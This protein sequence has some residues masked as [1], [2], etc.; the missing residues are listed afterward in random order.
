MGSGRARSI[1]PAVFRGRALLESPLGKQSLEGV[2]TPTT[3]GQ[4]DP[5]E[6]ENSPRTPPPVLPSSALRDILIL[7]AG[8]AGL[9]AAREIVGRHK[10]FLVLDAAPEIGG[11]AGSLLWDGVPVDH[12]AQFFTQRT[13]EFFRQTDDWLARGVTREWARGGFHRLD[14]DGQLHAPDTTDG[15]PRYACPTGMNALSRALAHVVPAE[16]LELNARAVALRRKIAASENDPAAGCW[17]VTLDNGET[18]SGRALIVT[19]PVPQALAL[20]ETAP[21][22]TQDAATLAPLRGV[23][24]S[25]CIALLRRVRPRADGAALP[26]HDWRGVQAREDAVLSWISADWTKRTCPLPDDGGRVYVLHGSAGFSQKWVAA[27]ETAEAARLMLA[28]AAEMVGSWI[29]DPAFTEPGNS[30]RICVWPYALVRQGFGDPSAPCFR[31][32]MTAGEGAAAKNSPPL[33]LAG[34]AFLGA[35]VEGAWRSGRA[36]AES[37]L[38]PQR[39]VRPFDL[40]WAFPKGVPG[41][42]ASSGSNPL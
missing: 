21:E 19:L 5:S 29:A 26:E 15:H 41:S 32:P 24:Q 23:V 27:D 8:I 18:R 17:E 13:P 31:L 36:A 6:M 7:G 28:R 3:I 1:A 38:P 14:A 22:L 4:I 9:T 20:L 25:P 35:K 30:Q 33:V 2:A 16:A 11:R 34:D 40:S 37:L 39:R 42:K 12:G 10:S